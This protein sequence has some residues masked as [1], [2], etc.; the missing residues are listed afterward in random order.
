MYRY[1]RRSQDVLA[2]LHPDLQVLCNHL[3]KLK[4]TALIE[5]HRSDERQV[6]L[7]AEGKTK[8]GPGKSKHNRKP[9]EA[10]DMLPW[11]F[12]QSDWKDRDKFHLHA[13]YVLAVADSL[14][15]QGLMTRRVRWGGDWRRDWEPSDNK[16]DDFPHFELI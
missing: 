12:K 2:T 15:E 8:V 9:S 11:P 6:E 5:G 10:V 16:F 13:G 1:G 3:I 7:L 4:D 14:Y